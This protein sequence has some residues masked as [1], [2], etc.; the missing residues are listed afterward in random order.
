LV[1][2]LLVAKL[3]HARTG[4]AALANMLLMAD[5]LGYNEIIVCLTIEIIAEIP[6]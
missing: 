3:A 5:T 6:S 4:F 1:N 2:E